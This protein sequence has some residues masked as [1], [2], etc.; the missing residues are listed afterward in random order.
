MDL[1]IIGPLV[2]S[3]ICYKKR[4]IGGA[5]CLRYYPSDNCCYP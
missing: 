4:R 5:I 3:V 2:E 1:S